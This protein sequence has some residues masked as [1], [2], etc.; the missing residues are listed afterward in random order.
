MIPL[1]IVLPTWADVSAFRASGERCPSSNKGELF[2]L[3]PMDSDCL[4]T[5]KHMTTAPPLMAVIDQQ[6]RWVTKAR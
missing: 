4:P 5:L 1:K 2:L 3:A 6:G